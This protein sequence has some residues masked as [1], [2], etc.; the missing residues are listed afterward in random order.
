MEPIHKFNNGNGAT[1]CTKCGAMIA[2]GLHEVLLCEA[3]GGE[4]IPETLPLWSLIRFEDGK[5]MMGHTI[6]WIEWGEDGRFKAQHEKPQIGFSL[7]L[8]PHPVFFGWQ[9]TQI[10][11]LI[12]ETEKV[13]EFRTGNSHYRLEKQWA[14]IKGEPV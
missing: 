1:L 4:P 9:T 13:V 8:D 11:E 5:T 2:E 14:E 10:T 3:C 6:I 7:M 12:E